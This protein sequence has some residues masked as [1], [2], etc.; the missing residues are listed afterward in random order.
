MK[1][2]LNACKW[3]LGGFG[4]NYFLTQK[5]YPKTGAHF[6]MSK[7]MKKWPKMSKNY[8]SEF[9]TKT[10]I[11]PFYDVLKRFWWSKLH[12]EGVFLSFLENLK[13]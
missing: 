9:A 3:V 13:F 6:L 8:F 4:E 1:P 12:M 10:Y 7:C 5:L 2:L 11:N